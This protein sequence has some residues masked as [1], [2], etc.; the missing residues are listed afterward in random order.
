MERQK[1]LYVSKVS[2]A[3]LVIVS[4]KRILDGLWNFF[5]LCKKA[6][7]EVPCWG[8]KVALII[9]NCPAHNNL[10]AIELV[11]LSP[12]TTSKTQP[13]VIREKSPGPGSYHRV[14]SKN[15]LY[16]SIHFQGISRNFFHFSRHFFNGQKGILG[17]NN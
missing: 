11:F 10:K 14:A 7:C 3:Y 13:V 9:D 6:W 15:W 16:F 4:P 17:G 1:I 12:S 8:R 2:K 5:W